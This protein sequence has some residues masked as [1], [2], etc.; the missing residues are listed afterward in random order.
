MENKCRV[1]EM[2]GEKF[3][4]KR[5]EENSQEARLENKNA[6]LLLIFEM[7]KHLNLQV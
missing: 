3:Q 5:M 7:K 4:K 2:F 1:S 6:V